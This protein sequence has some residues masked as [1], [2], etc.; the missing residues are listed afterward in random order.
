MQLVLITTNVVS[1]NSIQAKCI[2]Y[3]IMWSSLSVTSGR[4]MISPGTPVYSTNKTNW[5]IVESGVKHFNHKTPVII[6][7]MVPQVVAT[8]IGK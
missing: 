7:V 4:S 1:S 2:R 8:M 5:N 3:N 6:V